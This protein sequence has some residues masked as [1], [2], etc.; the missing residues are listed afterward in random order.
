MTLIDT[1]CHLNFEAYDK[2]RHAIIREAENQDVMRIINPG[3]D[4]TSSRQGIRLADEY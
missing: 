4:I 2:D 3:I 1:H